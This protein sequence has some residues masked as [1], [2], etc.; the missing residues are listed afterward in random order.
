LF[1]SAKTRANNKKI[2]FT[3]TKEDVIIP[4]KCPVFGITLDS[5]DRLHAPT[6]DRIINNLGYVKGNI[7]II[8]AK[9]NRL[10]NNGTI[11]EFEKIL[12][13]MKND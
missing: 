4:D 7:K 12:K 6:L 3:I 5:R 2:S 11:E 1:Y 8:S 13:Y 9:A 10:K